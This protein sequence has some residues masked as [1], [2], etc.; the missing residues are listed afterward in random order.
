MLHIQD[1]WDQRRLVGTPQFLPLF[2]RMIKDDS[3]LHMARERAARWPRPSSGRERRNETCVVGSR[4]P[5]AASCS[6]KPRARF[7]AQHLPRRLH[8]TAEQQDLMRAVSEA[9]NSTVDMV[10]VLE[11]HPEEISE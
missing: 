8:P 7:Q 1:L 11:A 4:L 10:R 2:D 5:L 9:A 3:Y 6:V